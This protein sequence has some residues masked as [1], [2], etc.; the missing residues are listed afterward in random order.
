MVFGDIGTSPLYAFKESISHVVRSGAALNTGDV[1]GVISL[2]F[3]ALM[4]VVTFKYVALLMRFDNKG[5]GGVLA[6][7]ALAQRLLGTRTAFFVGMSVLGAALFYGDAMLTPAISVLSAIEGLT[8]L[9]SLQGHIDPFIVPIALGVLFALFLVQNKGTA[10]VGAWFGPICILWFLVIGALGALEIVRAPAVLAAVN[11]LYAITLIAGHPI[12]AFVLLGSVFLTVTGAEA[13]YA[14][15]GH[16]GRTPISAAWTFLVLPAL[17]LNY[18]GQ[19]ALVLQHP[20]AAE[21]PFFLMAPPIMQPALVALATAATIIASQAVIS[22]AFSLT[23]QAIQLGFLPRLRIVQTSAEH[24]GQIFMP[25][26]NLLLLIGVLLLVVIFKSS[27]ALASAYGIS[28]IGAMITSSVLALVAIWKMWKKP[29]WFAIAVMSPFILVEGIFLASNMLKL[30]SG[31]FV[32]LLIASALVIT[33]WTWMKGSQLLKQATRGDEPLTSFL[34][35]IARNPPHRVRGTAVF[36]TSE[37]D[38]TPTA[39]LHNL[40]HNQVLHDR[41]IIACVRTASEPR[42]PDD[43][44]AMVEHLTPD[45]DRV[46]LTFGF[47]Q[48]PNVSRGL[49]LARVKGVQ[50]DPL[51]T[52]F[53]VSRRVLSPRSGGGMPRWQDLLYIWLARNA[54]NASVFFHIPAAR[55]VELGAQLS[56]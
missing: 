23:Q 2:M 45:I 21:N 4:I 52:S 29:L 24:I 7:A 10:L 34:H 16:F 47:M 35:L 54:T 50:F 25:Q 27:S 5:E 46:T 51:K 39:M 9:P 33:M 26:V 43:R 38:V 30:F 19:G 55:T 32:P 37:P 28:V 49:T 6:L 12:L 42:V 18:M 20:A 22:G 31:G 3:W 1:L 8:I 36:L 56:I 41:I 40:K 15:M 48:D 17:T 14:D 53:F 44:I 11:P 13:L